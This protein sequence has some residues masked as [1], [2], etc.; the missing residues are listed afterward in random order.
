MHFYFLLW[1]YV[2]VWVNT[3]KCAPQHV[4]EAGEA[5]NLLEMEFLLFHASHAR[6]AG[7]CEHLGISLALPLILLQQS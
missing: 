4:P 2:F 1:V 5:S 7:I 3:G 6:L